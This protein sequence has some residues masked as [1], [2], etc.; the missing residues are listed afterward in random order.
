MR[1]GAVTAIMDA[2][3]WWDYYVNTFTSGHKH[4]EGPLPASI[5]GMWYGTSIAWTG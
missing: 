3:E 4:E 5:T 1:L 2:A